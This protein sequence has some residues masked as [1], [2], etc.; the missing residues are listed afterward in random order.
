MSCR[1]HPTWIWRP[2]LTRVEDVGNGMGMLLEWEE[3]RPTNENKQI[4]Y[5]IR[6]ADTRFGI[7][8][9]PPQLVT[10]ARSVIVNMDEPGNVFYASVMATE[11]D[12]NTDI[13]ITQMNQ[14]GVDLFQYPATQ[15]LLEDLVESVDGYRIVITD[16]SGYP[17][18]GEVLV[19]TEVMRYTSVDIPNNELVV[20]PIDRAIIDSAL[21]E[22]FAGEEVRMWKGVEDGNS[23][24]RQSHAAWHQLT[25]RNIDEIGEYNVDEDG[26]RAANQDNITTDLSAAD[27]ENID[28]PAYD[29]CGYHRPSLQATFTGQCVKSYLGGQFNGQRGFNFQERNLSRLDTM[30]QVTGESVILLRRV[31]SGKR[32]KCIGLRRE[33]QRTRCSQCFGTGFD[34]GYVRYINPRAVSE[35]EPNTRGFIKVRIYPHK[36]DLQ[37]KPDQAL[38]QDTNPPAWTL[39]VPTVKDRD[40]IIRFNIDGTEEFRYEIQDVT[41][42][43]LFFGDSGKQEFNMVRL[44]KTDVIYQFDVSTP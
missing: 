23:I 12:I 4:H 44:D 1:E 34:G 43:K 35:F 15:E 7:L 10:T 18:E 6:I 19:G 38:M 14:V 40:V 32:C 17:P 28:F 26:Y 39:S 36:D 29:F 25:P 8:N 22:H 9:N 42:N 41:R 33:H 37:I 21:S 2:G 30:L 20:Q 27:Q 13:D 11:F 31:W 3:A 5:N 24:I 16:V